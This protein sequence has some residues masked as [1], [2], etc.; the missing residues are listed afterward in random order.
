MKLK[1]YFELYCIEL[2]KLWSTENFVLQIWKNM[3]LEEIYPQCNKLLE[4]LLY[5]YI[6]HRPQIC[7][8]N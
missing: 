4:S 5:K 2:Y 1:L 3:Q 7:T 6:S 8:C